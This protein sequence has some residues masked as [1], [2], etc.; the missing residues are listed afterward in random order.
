[1]L[2][3]FMFELG[4]IASSQRLKVHFRS[5]YILV[6]VIFPAIIGVRLGDLQYQINQVWMN[7]QVQNRTTINRES[8][9][10]TKNQS[11]NNPKNY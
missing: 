4:Q 9:F 7:F 3:T 10:T 1:M 11:I 6:Y 5:I 2:V 8:K